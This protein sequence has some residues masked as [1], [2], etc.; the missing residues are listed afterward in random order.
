MNLKFFNED[1]SIGNLAAALLFSL[2]F[3]SITI[4]YFI[5]EMKIDADISEIPI[6]DSLQSYSSEQNFANNSYNLNT[7]AHSG[8]SNWQV[9]DTI[10]AKLIQ[11]GADN[12]Y[13]YIM[14]INPDSSYQVTNTYNIEN[15]SKADYSIVLAGNT[16]LGNNEI[17][18]KQD[19]FHFP[20]YSLITGNNYL[21]D[22]DFIP[23]PNA[24]QVVNVTITSSY[25]IGK[26]TC[27]I[28]STCRDERVSYVSFVFNGMT[29][30]NDR[31]FTSSKLNILEGDSQTAFYG[32]VSSKTTGIVLKSFHT[33]NRIAGTGE[34]KDPL[35][36]IASFISLVLG[37][38]GWGLPES[39][40][41]AVLNVLLIKTQEVALLVCVVV[42]LRGGGI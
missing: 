3:S 34:Q 26:K 16:G 10:G 24:N 19:G 39:V 30:Y 28:F 33:G 5:T 23:Y 6:P 9:I 7:V 42:I 8:S 18:V 13:F 31:T 32:G 21:T 1:G 35:T 22:C 2:I 37:I 14:N 11:L 15:P 41:P 38:L 17:I 40:M 4:A 20:T 25:T 36:Q 27:A 12:S 29:S